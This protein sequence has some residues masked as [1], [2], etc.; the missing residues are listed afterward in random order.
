MLHAKD[1]S[2]S[3]STQ[4]IWPGPG[5]YRMATAR[6]PSLRSRDD[7]RSWIFFPS[8]NSSLGRVRKEVS[9]YVLAS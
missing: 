9:V 6:R 2:Y 4:S 3:R 8:S 7:R 5:E 1:V